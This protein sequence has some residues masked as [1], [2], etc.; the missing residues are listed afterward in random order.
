M[1]IRSISKTCL[2]FISTRARYWHIWQIA[3]TTVLSSL[4]CIYF[5]LVS[6]LR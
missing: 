1:N 5:L 4:K 3:S 2:L 6:S